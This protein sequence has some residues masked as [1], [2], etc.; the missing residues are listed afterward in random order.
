M[1][2]TQNALCNERLSIYHARYPQYPESYAIPLV[3]SPGGANTHAVNV[4][5]AERDDY[6]SWTISIGKRTNWG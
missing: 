3:D 6:Y 4:I 2:I 5:T 1:T